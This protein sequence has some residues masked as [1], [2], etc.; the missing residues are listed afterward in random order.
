MRHTVS[1]RD[2]IT[3]CLSGP[4]SCVYLKGSARSSNTF[5]VII[6]GTQFRHRAT[7]MMLPGPLATLAHSFSALTASHVSAL[8]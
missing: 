4:C 6:T 5:T 7:F 8:V 2:L 1:H 3:T